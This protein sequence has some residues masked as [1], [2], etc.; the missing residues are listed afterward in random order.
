MVTKVTD[1]RQHRKLEGQS[2]RHTQVVSE[3][4]VNEAV[5]YRTDLTSNAEVYDL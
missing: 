3:A 2:D 5:M 1:N 4:E